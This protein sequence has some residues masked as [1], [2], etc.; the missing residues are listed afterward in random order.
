MYASRVLADTL[1]R[2]GST[3]LLFW[4]SDCSR[5]LRNTCLKRIQSGLKA[6]GH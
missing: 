1:T 3:T 4:V 2:D 6:S 5:I